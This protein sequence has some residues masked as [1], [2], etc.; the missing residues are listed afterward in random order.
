MKIFAIFGIIRK[1]DIF[2]LFSSGINHFR[3]ARDAVGCMPVD[4]E[5]L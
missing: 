4:G 1:R 2:G 5:S 3:A